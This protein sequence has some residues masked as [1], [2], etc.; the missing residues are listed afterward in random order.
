M[1]EKGLVFIGD[2]YHFKGLSD[3]S[4]GI[5]HFF[6]SVSD[7][8]YVAILSWLEE[9]EE[10]RAL[11]DQICRQIRESLRVPT[12]V[13]FGPRYLHSTG[14]LHKGD[15]NGGIFLQII[16]DIETNFPVPNHDYTFSDLYRAQADADFTVLSDLGRRVVR[17]NVGNNV[18]QGLSNL[19]AIFS[20]AFSSQ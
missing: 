1:K 20:S 11:F 7:G 18:T 5:T 13:N 2:P 4:I 10:V 3:I 9:S 8:D 14:Q 12:T 15:S 6:G 19:L 16:G 17:I